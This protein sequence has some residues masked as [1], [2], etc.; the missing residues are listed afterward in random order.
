M[1]HSLARTFRAAAAAVLTAAPLAACMG[2]APVELRGPAPAALEVTTLP[3][4]SPVGSMEAVFSALRAPARSAALSE[5]VVVISVDGLRPD[6]LQRFNAP[7]MQRLAREG[8]RSWR[9]QT[10]MPSKTLPSH[11]SMLT[12]VEPEV[13]GVEWNRNETHDHG[14]LATPTIFARARQAGLS[15]AGFFSKG[16]FNHLLVPGTFD[17]AIAPEGDGMWLAGK[18]VGRV[19]RYLEEHRPNL[20][21]VHVGEPDYAGHSFG[22][23]GTLYEWAVHRA[24]GAVG[25]VL[26]AADRAY[27][28]GNYTVIVTADHGGHGRSHGSSDPRDVTIPWIAWGKGVQPGTE[29]PDGI[30]TTQTAATALRLLGVTSGLEAAP[31]LAALDAPAGARLASEGAAAQTAPSGSSP[32]VAAPSVR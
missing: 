28:E 21:F 26:R 5:H 16:K 29:L 24:D 15:T 20:L 2:G 9:A 17:Y 8:S 30:H 19:E 6:A 7:T 11:T 14:L 1:T 10:I 22:W 31:V 12:G 3:A 18:T 25:R 32:A 27:G 23:M 4:P 13:H